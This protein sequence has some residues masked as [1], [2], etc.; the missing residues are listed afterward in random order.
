M[1]LFSARVWCFVMNMV[2]AWQMN[3]SRL[4]LFARRVLTATLLTYDQ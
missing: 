1:P 3:G 2:F 4:S